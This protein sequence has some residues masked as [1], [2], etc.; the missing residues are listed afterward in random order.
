[1]KKIGFIGI[2]IMGKSMAQNLQNHGYELTVY[3]RTR[4][5]AE[6]LLEKG[7]PHISASYACRNVSPSRKL[8]QIWLCVIVSQRADFRFVLID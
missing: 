3:S 6:P 1:M 7:L 8:S 4:K 5:K 2:G